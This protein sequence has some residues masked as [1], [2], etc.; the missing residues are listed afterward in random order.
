MYDKVIGAQK[1]WLTTMLVKMPVITYN[2]PGVSPIV[3]QQV[4][5]NFE[6][7]AVWTNLRTLD[8]LKIGEDAQRP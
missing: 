2:L 4:G 6:P 3:R 7:T 5:C 1:T 8:T